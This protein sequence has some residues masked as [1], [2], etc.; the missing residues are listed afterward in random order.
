[1]SDG[2]AVLELE[3]EASPRKD[4]ECASDVIRMRASV[5]AEGRAVL[6][7]DP[8]NEAAM[9][10]YRRLCSG[11]VEAIADFMEGNSLV[12]RFRAPGGDPVEVEVAGDYFR[13]A[14]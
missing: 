7:F 2:V 6:L 10:A 9:V 3:L 11:P 5:D 12:V 13:E 8:G 4:S 1:M 14:E